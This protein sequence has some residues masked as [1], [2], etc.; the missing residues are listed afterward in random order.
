MPGHRQ[1]S[2]VVRKL[3]TL[4]KNV[5]A[6]LVIMAVLFCS[7]KSGIEPEDKE[8][9]VKGNV[10]TTISSDTAKLS[11]LINI[12]VFRPASAKF[13]YVFIDNSGQK[14]RGFPPGP[15]DSHLEAVLTFDSKTIERLR[16]LLYNANFP[17]PKYKAESFDFDWLDDQDKLALRSVDSTYSGTPDFIFELGLN[18]KL[19]ITNCKVFVVK[20]TN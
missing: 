11:R 9:V 2:A 16:T 13:K 10:T 19:W 3:L 7:C 5:F 8:T 15:S 1:V 20:S 6:I 14:D 18:G 4:M 17:D 12:H